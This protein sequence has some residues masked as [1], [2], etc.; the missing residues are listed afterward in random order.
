MANYLND[1]NRWTAIYQAVP[2]KGGGYDYRK[3]P[4][5]LVRFNTDTNPDA[6][7]EIVPS[8]EKEDYTG[9]GTAA[10]PDKVTEKIYERIWIVEGAAPF[11]QKTGF[12]AAE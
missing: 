8:G 1:G 10:T 11:S 7:E 3:L 6:V 4:F 12:G 5:E 9:F 2:K